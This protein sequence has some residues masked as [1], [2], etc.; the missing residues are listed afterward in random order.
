MP[1]YVGSS[2]LEDYPFNA[3]VLEALAKKGVKQLF[4]IQV[5]SFPHVYS[6]RDVVAKARTGTGKTLA[7]ALPII[8]RLLDDGDVGCR[9]PR[10][11]VVLPTRELAIQ[12]ARDFIDIGQGLRSTC[13]Y[14]GADYGPQER[15]LRRGVEVVVGTPGRLIDFLEKGTL[16][17]AGCK[18]VV[19]DEAD[20][21]LNMGFQEDVERILGFV[22]ATQPTQKMLFS[23]TIPS[24]VKG[25]SAKFL[26]DPITID[27]V[28]ANGSTASSTTIRHLAIACDWRERQAV[29]A[30]VVKVY[31]T[32]TKV[33]V[34]CN[35]KA[36][37]NQLATES[38]IRP[39]SEA[40]HGDVPQAQREKTTTSFRNGLFQCLIATDV[41]ARGLDIDGVGLVI[42]AQP[43]LDSETYIHRSGRTGRAG[44]S[45]VCILFYTKREQNLITRIERDARIKFERI[46]APQNE[47]LVRSAASSAKEM[48][49]DVHADARVFFEDAANELIAEM[50]A[51]TALS[52]ALARM[53]NQ[54]GP[55]QT[56]SLM[57]S[58]KDYTSILCTSKM[59]MRSPMYVLNAI[60]EVLGDDV[61]MRD[62]AIGLDKTVA[63]AEVPSIHVDALLKSK[64][65]SMTFE[66]CKQLPD[67]EIKRQTQQYGG[68]GGG[69]GGFRG[70]GGG[71]FRGGG[72][73]GGRGGGGFRGGGGGGFRGG[74]GGG[75]GGGYRGRK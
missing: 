1:S 74:G 39:I 69:G 46:G 6:G 53:T 42:Q 15:E 64:L 25:I 22:P 5:Q 3:A 62:I 67:L 40:L 36:E 75:G 14:G 32:G 11:I 43:P 72:G 16:S 27:L 60:K 31:G 10:V 66:V 24:W 38:G 12:V 13:I 71:G 4:D 50:G 29:L 41:A 70:G 2:K 7:F 63:V 57:S 8:Q 45:G 68:G 28:G 18:Y 59:E 37:A 47:D 17:L 21:M 33:L 20:E 61:Q 51:T 44:K 9:E 52:A 58:L 35:T 26:R 30:D 54:H 65:R 56:R 49:K 23:A 73:G 19:L 34:F 55:L 48:L